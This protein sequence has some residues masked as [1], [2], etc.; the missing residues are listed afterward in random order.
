MC[1]RC[2]EAQ[3]IL[4][5]SIVYEERR[6]CKCCKSVIRCVSCEEVTLNLVVRAAEDGALSAAEMVA[7]ERSFTSRSKGRAEGRL[8]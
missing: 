4:E 8:K 3:K 6:E 7:L 5:A 1:K 2:V